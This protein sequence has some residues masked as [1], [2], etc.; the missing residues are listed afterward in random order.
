MNEVKYSLSQIMTITEAAERYG[1][2][3]NTLKNKF[4]PSIVGQERLDAWVKHGLVKQSG[5]TWLIT[6]TFM[7]INFK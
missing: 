2:N 5:K 7:E 3:P 4:K 6:D 1:I